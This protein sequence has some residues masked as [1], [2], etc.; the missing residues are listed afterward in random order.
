MYSADVNTS[1]IQT[2]YEFQKPILKFVKIRGYTK[3][4]NLICIP[5]LW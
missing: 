3:F 1:G 4:L 5:D 2:V